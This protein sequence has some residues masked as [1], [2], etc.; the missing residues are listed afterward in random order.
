M[1]RLSN[2]QCRWIL[3]AVL[4][5]GFALHF[6]FLA[7]N[8]PLGLAG[9]EAQYWDWSRKLDYNYYSKPP[10]VAWLIRVS[11]SMFGD[12]VL[13]VRFPAL[14]LAVGTSILTYIAGARATGSQ[15]VGLGAVLLNHLVP[16][17]I[18]GSVIMTIDPP[19]F[20]FWALSGVFAIE[21]LLHDKKYAWI[22]MG[23][24]LGLGFL[25]KYMAFLFLL[26]IIAQFIFNPDSRKWLKS[27]FFYAMLL[28]AGL[29]ALPPLIWNLRHDWVSA[30]HVAADTTVGFNWKNP[31]LFIGGQ[32]GAVGPA[33]AL[34]MGAGVVHAWKNRELP[35]ARGM[36]LL[37]CLCVPY[38]ALVGVWSFKTSIQVNWPAPAYFSGIILSAAFLAERLKIPK[39]WKFWRWCLWGT[40]AIGLPLI[41]LMHN[42]PM[43]YPLMLKLRLKPKQ[44]DPSYK[45]YGPAELGARVSEEMKKLKPDPMIIGE[46]Y[47]FASL[48]AFYVEGRPRT[49]CVGSWF[50]KEA[51]RTRW[52]QFDIWDDCRLDNPGLLGKDAV[53]W[54]YNPR[55]ATND[56]QDSGSAEDFADAFESFTQLP[57]VEIKRNGVLVRTYHIF[58]GKNYR[59]LLH[60]PEATKH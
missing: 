55:S 56:D 60:R 23:F 43:Y 44:W 25:S 41:P 4:A 20:F 48:L 24:S 14:L 49:F 53:F 10:M 33:L 35:H 46:K 15:R 8:C 28:I 6:R 57:P 2:A 21:A 9:D 18:A 54:G 59:T 29:F 34:I 31:L 26:G 58:I 17:F 1:P 50:A 27:P 45:M 19:V 42:T 7:H 52:S 47:D 39:A 37:A 30:K 38:F 13:G 12:T 51:R 11:C 40:V 5:I 16:M 36:F 3:F 22:A 32:I